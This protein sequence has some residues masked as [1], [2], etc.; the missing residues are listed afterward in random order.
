MNNRVDCEIG[1]EPTR[2][3]A[4][5]ADGWSYPNWVIGVTHVR[6]VDPDWPKVGSRLHHTLGVW[7]LTG[8]NHAE[9]LEVDADRRLVLGI[10]LGRLGQARVE[11][12]IRPAPGGSAVSLS[13]H[14]DDGLVGAVPKLLADRF[15]RARNAESL[16]RLRTVAE[17]RAVTTVA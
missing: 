9:V 14:G 16:R 13:E 7:P 4:V 11:L 17:T 2:V 1:V 10:H 3:F 12:T 6:D 15:I 8:E 5:L